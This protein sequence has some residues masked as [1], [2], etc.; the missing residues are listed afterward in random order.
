MM[1]PA[2]G[3]CEAIFNGIANVRVYGS[4]IFL[5]E[6]EKQNDALDG[7]EIAFYRNLSNNE[8]FVYNFFSSHR[9]VRVSEFP[10]ETRNCC[11]LSMSNDIRTGPI[12]GTTRECESFDPSPP[13]SPFLFF[14]FSAITPIAGIIEAPSPRAR[15]FTGASARKSRRNF[16][17]IM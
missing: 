15:S 17:P 16:I 5:H 4:L 12:D 6:N 13:P 1:C 8:L 14:F 2:L 11:R 7:R 10:W 3:D 9:R